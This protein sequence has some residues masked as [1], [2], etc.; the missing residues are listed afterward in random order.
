VEW[1]GP[2]L[3]LL[4]SDY[5]SPGGTGFR[6]I[7]CTIARRAPSVRTVNVPRFVDDPPPFLIFSAEQAVPFM[8]CL[9]VGFMMKELL[10]MSVI[11]IGV[12][13][14]YARFLYSKPDGYLYH[15]M[16]WYGIYPGK[17]RLFL[18]PFRRLFIS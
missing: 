16:Y 1:K 15:A 10:L 9:F 4:L 13:W 2:N 3:P 12:A 7:D 11:G 5:E 18:N 6:R 14:V 8:A 17:G